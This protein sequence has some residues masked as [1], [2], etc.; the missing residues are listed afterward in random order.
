[1][2]ETDANQPAQ[3]AQPAQ[4]RQLPIDARVHGTDGELGRLTDVIINPA[5]RTVT[6]VVVAEDDLA[7]REYLVPVEHIVQTDRETVRLDC[8]RDDLRRFQEFTAT[9]Y[10][11]AGS[12]EAQP[13]IAEWQASMASMSYGPYDYQPLALPYVVTPDETVPVVDQR[14]PEGDLAFDRGTRV[15]SQDGKGL[16]EVEAFV[17]DPGDATITHFV[18]RQGN[19]ARATEVTLP[20]ST[21]AGV[22]GGTARLKLSAEDVQH[23]PAVPARRHYDPASGG[24]GT[25]ELLGLVFPTPDGAEQGLR[26]VKEATERGQVPRVDAAV[27]SKNADGKLSSREVHDVTAGRGAVVGAVAGAALSLLAGPL[28]LVA[29]AAA[30]GAVGGVVGGLVDRGVPDRY[31]RDL[32]RSLRPGTSALIV[33]VQRDAADALLEALRPLGGSPLRL[34]LTDEMVAKLTATR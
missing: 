13:V 30:G 20:V 10:V 17:F 21:V 11:P 16:G 14:V 28:G 3:P 8:S 29:G 25:L 24:P 32:G 12:P 9:R 1:M 22:S 15:E 23:L 34:A 7:G 33:L 5:R 6:H 27:L 18:L 19:L 2:S 4:P 31:V 26:V